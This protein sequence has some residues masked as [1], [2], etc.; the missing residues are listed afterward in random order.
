MERSINN[1]RLPGAPLERPWDPLKPLRPLKHHRS[2][3]K[4]PG[5]SLTPWNTICMEISPDIAIPDL[6]IHIVFPE[7][8]LIII[9][10]IYLLDRDYLY[11][12]HARM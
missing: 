3:L 6:I 10:N 12:I 11:H 2:S 1:R 7:Q 9:L 8:M 5:S 4:A